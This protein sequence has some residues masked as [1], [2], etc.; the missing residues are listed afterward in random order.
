[1]RG[2][3][4]VRDAARGMDRAIDPCGAPRC[5]AGGLPS[6]DGPDDPGTPP[7]AIEL[8]GVRRHECLPR[9]ASALAT[10]L[11]A[12]RSWRNDVD[13]RG[14]YNAGNGPFVAALGV[15][16]PV[17]HPAGAHRARQTSAERPHERMHRMLKAET[18]RPAAGG[19]FV[20]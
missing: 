2:D 19:S 13:F 17:R 1:P 16:G 6:S 20:Y 12:W 5:R 14:M 3:L 18:T 10:A 9:S 8:A 7:R 4:H 15:V 11:L